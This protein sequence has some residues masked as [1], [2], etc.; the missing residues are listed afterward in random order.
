[1]PKWTEAQMEAIMARNHTI[2]VSAAAGSGK[3]AVLVERIVTLLKEG[4]RLERM[5]I[6]TFTRAAA[7]EM[8]QRLNDRLQQE[9]KQEPKIMSQALADLENTEISTIHSF[10]QHLLREEFQAAGI[11]PLSTICEEQKRQAIFHEAWQE[12]MNEL[13]EEDQPVFLKLA[14]AITPELMEKWVT[15]LHEF[16]MSLPH[17]FQWLEEK[18]A[19]TAAEPFAEQDWYHVLERYAKQQ[20]TGLEILVEQER[21][22]LYQPGAIVEREADYENDR[23]TYASFQRQVQENPELLQELLATYSLK[24]AK[25]VKGIKDMPEEMQ[26]WD[27]R[28]KKLRT[29]QKDLAKELYEILTLDE[30]KTRK[31]LGQ[32]QESVQGLSLLVKRTAEKFQQKKQEKNLLDFSDLEQMTVELLDDENQQARLKERF[33]HIFVDECQ[34]VSAVQDAIIQRLQG[35][36]TCLFMVGDV[37]QSIYRFRQ[38]DPTLFLHRMRTFSD[39][40]DARERRIFLQKNFRSRYNVLDAT[41]RVFRKLMKADVTELDYLPEDELICGR[42]TENDPP[43]ELIACQEVDDDDD[44]G[45]GVTAR[46]AQQALTAADKIAELTKVTFFDGKQ[47]RRYTYRDMVI[48]MPTVAGVAQTVSEV[49]ES[50]GVPVYFDGSDNYFELPEIKA[51]LELLN[52]IDDELQDVPLLSALKMPP[53]LMTDQELADI[54]QSLLGRDVPFHQAFKACCKEPSALG[55][56]CRD[57]QDQLNEW[58]FY[59]NTLSLADFLWKVMGETGMFAVSGTLPEGEARQANLMLLCQRAAEFEDNGGVS[60]SGFLK[61][62]G[63]MKMTQDTKSAKVLG[64]NE[65]LVRIMTIHKSKGLEFPVVFLMGMNKNLHRPEGKSL[66]LHSQLGVSLP[67]MNP[68]LSIRRETKRD[69][70]FDIQKKLD[71]KAERARLLY[72][73]MTR[74]RERLILVTDD[75]DDGTVTMKDSVYRVWSAR[76]MESWIKQAVNDEKDY[77]AV[78]TGFPQAANPWY[79]TV[80]AQNETQAVEKE[81]VTGALQGWLHQLLETP[82]QTDLLEKWRTQAAPQEEQPLKTSVSSVVRKRTMKDPLPMSGQEENVA[83][84]EKAEEIVAP[85]RLSEMPRRP[86]FMEQKAM[87]GAEAGT[88]HHRVLALLDLTAL[89]NA[90]SMAETLSA[91]LVRLQ[92]EGYLTEEERR[93]VHPNGILNFLHSDM[94]QRLMRSPCVRREWRFNLR[95]RDQEDALLQGVIDC[96]FL[97]GKS[98]ILLDYK[99]DRIQDE[100]AFVERYRLQLKLYAEAVA[101]ITGQPVTETWLYSLKLGKAIPVV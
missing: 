30:E 56:K 48:L 42:E 86:V 18:T 73:G 72:V 43:V 38:A 44:S 61:V 8:R 27:K 95:L 57:A 88:L 33:R 70:A 47:E 63:E 46:I 20:L 7:A 10:C 101:N 76:K 92:E 22:M 54:R 41:N 52:V 4:E 25:T 80:S 37:K 51:M 39:E 3:T 2:L 14:D 21:Q 97:E 82:P 60:L 75:G 69:E 28:F 78:S 35:E 96:A 91:E 49:L 67:Y 1:M 83:D 26:E 5:M 71:E 64:E 50:K 9:L 40:K 53:F 79:I 36:N 100:G 93:A 31:E 19:V 81:S 98:W 12:A 62:I 23:E 74:A 13:L 68:A 17:P 87:T 55:K 29:K 15:Q 16:L 89:R 77:T 34:D 6:V 99:T 84:K 24:K 59:A 66:R 45:D 85:L 58:R 65:N 11:D 94:G 32:V 90:S